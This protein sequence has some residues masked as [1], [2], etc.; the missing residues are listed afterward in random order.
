[1]VQKINS[2]KLVTI[3]VGPPCSGKST[4]LKGMPHDYAISSGFIVAKLCKLHNISYHEYFGYSHTSAIKKKHNVLFK[5]MIEESKQ[6]NHVVWDLTNLMHSNRKKIMSY[7]PNAV[8]NAV[9]FDFKGNEQQLL[10]RND[11]RY[12]TSGKFINKTTMLDMFK[13]FEPVDLSEGISDIKNIHFT[14][15]K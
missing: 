4:Y 12:A 8:F 3:L 1:M 11:K 15:S 9:V 14:I 5:N 13:R 10:K 2:A 6:Y 7:Y